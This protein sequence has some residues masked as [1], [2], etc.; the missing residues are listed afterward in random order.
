M[1]RHFVAVLIICCVLCVE[2][3]LF[4]QCYISAILQHLTVAENCS[5]AF[6]T[7]FIP[8]VS[9]LIAVLIICYIASVK[10]MLH[11]QCCK[12]AKIQHLIVAE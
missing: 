5:Y 4:M 3:L 7:D 2:Y 1:V 6:Y 9:Y 12:I 8:M 10:C 11:M